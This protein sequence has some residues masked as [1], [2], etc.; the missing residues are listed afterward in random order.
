MSLIWNPKESATILEM[1]LDIITTGTQ[2][3]G[4]GIYWLKAGTPLDEYFAVSN[5][6]DAK[7]IVAEDFKFISTKPD[8]AKIVPLITAGYVDL[9]KAEA[10]SGLTYTDDCIAALG[11]AGIVMVDGTI[12]GGTSVVAN[13]TL[14]GT[15]DSLT[16]IQIGET[17]YAV[18]SGT[19]V[20]A[21]P[22]LAG[23]EDSLTGIQIG[24]TKYSVGGSSGGGALKVTVSMEPAS[25]P[26]AY[27]FTLDKTWQEVA[28]AYEQGSGAFFVLPM[29]STTIGIF[30]PSKID[31]H[32]SEYSVGLILIGGSDNITT[33]TFVTVTADGHPA[34]EH[35]FS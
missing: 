1:P 18:D 20:V 19:S 5:D 17:K 15:E 26:G 35:S 21:N 4:D 12:S 11:D 6:D 22:T 9:N 28:D 2:N 16:G 23:T 8:Q 25:T 3:M 13:P 34:C 33:L 24:E 14:A 31:S 27:L 30:I 7:Y 10:A 32:N 29:T